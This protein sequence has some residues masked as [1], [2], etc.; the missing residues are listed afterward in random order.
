MLAKLVLCAGSFVV[1]IKS[2]SPFILRSVER[3]RLIYQM[4]D[5]SD[6]G[7]Y[8][9]LGLLFDFWDRT[10]KWRERSEP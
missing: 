8:V 2:V 6:H 9:F 4:V 1:Y 10:G 7:T 3:S 5:F